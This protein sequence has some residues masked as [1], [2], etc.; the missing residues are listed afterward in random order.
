MRPFTSITATAVP[1]PIANIDTDQIIPKQFL[2]TI[3]RTGL[4]EGL[5]YDLRFDA[6]GKPRTDSVL[7]SAVYKGAQV[8]I[9]GENFGCGSS[10]EHAAWALDD[11]G[12]R[13]VIAP[14]FADIFHG[15]A[16]NN[17]ILTVALASDVVETLVGEARG[18]N[19]VFNIDLE[20][21]TVTAPSGVVHRFEID[22]A[23]KRKLLSGLDD[24]GVS[25]THAD[26]IKTFEARRKLA[27][28]WLP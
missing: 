25:L 11:F 12:I 28:P 9:A 17:G 6:A 26:A 24:I 16:L 5:F 3:A 27:T 1:L 15:N 4:G 18:G 13:C 14:S 8:L 21:Q 23:A 22:A 10:R 7:D 2:S 20:A 19:H